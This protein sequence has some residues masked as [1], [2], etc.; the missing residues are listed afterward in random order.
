MTIMGDSSTDISTTEQEMWFVR[1]CVKGEITV[2]FIGSSVLDKA[3][4]SSM[5]QSVQQTVTSLGMDW[6]MFRAKLVCLGCDVAN[7]MLG[8]K[9]GLAARFESRSTQFTASPLHGTSIG[10]IARTETV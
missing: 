3:D 9:S 10:I 6:N 4:A 1:L 8:E 5:Y 2:R 7:V